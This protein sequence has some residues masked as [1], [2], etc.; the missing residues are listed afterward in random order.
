MN[1]RTPLLPAGNV[2]VAAALAFGASIPIQIIGG[3]DPYPLIPPGLVIAVAVAAVLWYGARLRWTA[4]VGAAWAIFM[5]VGAIAA[6]STSHYLTEPGNTFGFL[7][8]WFQTL[9]LAVGLVASVTY[10]VQRYRPRSRV[11]SASS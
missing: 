8:T 2:T 5:T 3:I 1:T 11:G 10:A 6:H 9:S 7:S 4:L